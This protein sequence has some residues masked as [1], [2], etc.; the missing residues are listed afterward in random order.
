MEGRTDGRTDGP[1]DRQTFGHLG[2][3]KINHVL[4]ATVWIPIHL[5]MFDLHISH[6]K[7][8]LGKRAQFH[9][10]IVYTLGWVKFS[11]CRLSL[12]GSCKKSKR[13]Q[14]NHFLQF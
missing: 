4:F 13:T 6:M 1:T 5:E 2:G 12:R 7:N 11:E 8:V 9:L 3:S 14:P 10:Y